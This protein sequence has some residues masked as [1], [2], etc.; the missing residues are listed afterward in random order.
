MNEGRP[1]YH[2]EGRH[3]SDWSVKDI[4]YS[5]D[6]ARRRCDELRGIY[7]KVQFRIVV[8]IKMVLFTSYLPPTQEE[9]R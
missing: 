6:D 4:R 2:I 8:S 3:Q 7:P 5:E 9:Q 1:E